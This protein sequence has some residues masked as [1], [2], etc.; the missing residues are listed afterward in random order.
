MITRFYKYVFSEHPWNLGRTASQFYR[1]ISL[2][3]EK[4]SNDLD[5]W[6]TTY[7]SIMTF[8]GSTSKIMYSP[9]H[10]HFNMFLIYIELR[11]LCPLGSQR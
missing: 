9:Q 5:Q 6:I 1:K 4:L 2:D 8:S 11:I 3:R 10:L 7:F